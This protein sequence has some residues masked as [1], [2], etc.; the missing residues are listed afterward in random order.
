MK[1]NLPKRVDDRN[2]DERWSAGQQVI[3]DRPDGIDIAA[4]IHSACFPGVDLFGRHVSWRADD[5]SRCR[6]QFGALKPLGQPK[7]GDVQFAEFVD[8]H[9]GRLEVA[10][11]DT[12]LVGV[13]DCICKRRDIASCLRPECQL[14]VVEPVGHV[15][16]NSF[17]EM[18]TLAAEVGLRLDEQPRV[19]LSHTAL[20]TKAP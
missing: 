18:L 7:I 5:L 15:T 3:E 11:N 10:M 16:A 8:Q 6:Q 14:L 4:P 19:R 9:V 2:A 12:F 1:A 20:L 17:Q 13:V